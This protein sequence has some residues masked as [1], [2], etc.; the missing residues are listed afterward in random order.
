[1]GLERLRAVAVQCYWAL[2]IYNRVHC[3]MSLNGLIDKHFVDLCSEGVR[4]VRWVRA[5][6]NSATRS[7]WL[8]NVQ[9]LGQGLLHKLPESALQSPMP[10]LRFR[11]QMH[12]GNWHPPY[13]PHRNGPIVWSMGPM[14]NTFRPRLQERRRRDKEL[15]SF[16]VL[17]T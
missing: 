17:H 9:S 5:C 2:M 1:M 15:S 4:W 6:S 11:R 10:E 7:Q 8:W 3:R 16:H 12:S 13:P 14:A